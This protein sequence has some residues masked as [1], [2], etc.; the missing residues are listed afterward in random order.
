MFF[1]AQIH[2]PG[3]LRG[4]GVALA[5]PLLQSMIPA[6]VHGAELPKARLA[7]LYMAHARS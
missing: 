4:S 7:C 2:T 5:L 6:G 3:M 1:C